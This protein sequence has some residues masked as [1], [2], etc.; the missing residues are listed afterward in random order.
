MN[1]S[2]GPSSASVEKRTKYWRAPSVRA[3]QE[4][5]RWSVGAHPVGARR[6]GTCSASAYLEKDAVHQGLLRFRA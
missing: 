3:A 1:N 4:L 2:N 6:Y 5:A